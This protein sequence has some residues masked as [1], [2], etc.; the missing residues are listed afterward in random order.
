MLD[1]RPFAASKIL[2]SQTNTSIASTVSFS[3][4]GS[5]TENASKSKQFDKLIEKLAP[6]SSKEP[7]P[8]VES[9]AKLEKQKSRSDTN[10]KSASHENL[11]I[12]ELHT[13]SNNKRN[14]SYIP[15]LSSTNST[16]DTSK[17]SSHSTLLADYVN[18]I[19]FSN[20][21][22]NLSNNLN[23]TDSTTAQVDESV[24]SLLRRSISINDDDFDDY[25]DD[26]DD[27]ED[28]DDEQIE[29]NYRHYSQ[30]ET[31]ELN[32]NEISELNSKD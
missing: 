31:F 5:C 15:D 26:V 11:N 16:T 2:P 17:T 13:N 29:N 12:I 9:K 19:K 7:G 27:D 24:T 6:A 20:S 25:N 3:V 1:S 4:Q 22:P 23:K 8:L 18:N 32:L 21:E 10:N 14:V 28:G 30:F